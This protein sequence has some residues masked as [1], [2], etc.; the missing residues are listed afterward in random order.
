MDTINNLLDTRPTL[1]YICAGAATSASLYFLWRRLRGERSALKVSAP[2][3]T[4]VL[5]QIPRGTY[6]PSISPFPIK[7]ESFLRLHNIPYVCD[8]KNFKSPKGKLPYITYN[9]Q[10]VS[11]S[12]LAME[13]LKQ[14]LH[15]DDLDKKLSDEQKA[16][17]NALRVLV[18]EHLYWTE[19][20]FR[21][22]EKSYDGKLFRENFPTPYFAFLMI[23]RK[24]TRQAYDQGMGRHTAEEVMMFV[25]KAL[26]SLDGYLGNKNFLM[27]DDVT[28][29]DCAVFGHLCQFVYIQDD[30][31]LKG[32]VH[33]QFPRL[34]AYTERFK[35]KVWPDW[36]EVTRMGSKFKQA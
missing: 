18:D 3:G 5:H 35:A 30:Q 11:D 2:P 31:Y 14:K 23:K 12:Q 8:F 21:W 4:V 24:L 7:L 16:V 28:E 19:L 32:V 22:V 6:A 17:A 1:T 29:V 26:A 15:L 33:K 13:F 20:Y 9:G 10:V 34:L 27:G 25:R 36:E